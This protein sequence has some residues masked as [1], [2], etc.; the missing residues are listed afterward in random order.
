MSR[1]DDD[2]IRRVREATDLVALASERVVLRQKGRVFWG[3]CPFHDEK[4]PSFKIDPD[5]QLWHCFGCGKGGDV[6]GYVMESENVDFP[7]AVRELA[8]RAHIE[9]KETGG[10]G[11]PRSKR[12]RMMDACKDAEEFYHRQLMRSR[13]KGPASARAYLHG[14]GFGSKAS[15]DWMLGYAPGRGALVSYLKGKGYTRDVLIDA[16]LAVDRDGRLSDRFYERVI[17]PVHDVQGRCVAFGGRVIGEGEPKYLNSSETPIFHKSD[18]L[19]GVD[20]AK[21]AMVNTRQAVV[22]EGYTDVI[23]LHEAGVT[24]AVAALGTS[25]TAQ[26][27][28]LLSRFA[29]T[30]V[31]LFD[32]DAAGQKA[33][34]R[35][36]EFIDWQSAIES[37]RDPIDLRVVVIPDDKDP[38]DYIESDGPEAM[39]KLIAEKSEP[40]LQF[41]INRCLDGYDLRKPEQKSHAMQQALKILYP[42]KGSVSA[43]DYVN[44]IADRLNVD[45]SSVLQAFRETKAPAA[46]RRVEEDEA[47]SRARLTQPAS[48]AAADI[49]E[50]DQQSVR[51]ERKLVSLV[52][53]DTHL[54]DDMA[55]EIARVNWTDEASERMADAL[56]ELDRDATPAQAL[57][58][59]TAVCPEAPSLLS[60]VMGESSEDEDPSYEA[61]LLVRSL[62]ERDLEGMIRQSKARMRTQAGLSP[63]ELDELFEETVAM[64]KELKE[65]RTQPS[66]RRQQQSKE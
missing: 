31:Y 13:E 66:A 46:A 58:A 28:K 11:V 61:R 7:D 59:V 17:F 24:N 19:Y 14:R 18:N 37:R 55:A 15:N 32:G 3:C 52:V 38:A 44:L 20:R 25:L 60:A 62:R 30:I 26:H 54:L 21:S 47:V 36:S 39:R 35:A 65:L 57:M 6:F 64:Q 53:T 48:R 2:D 5:T 1:I 50:T 10:S 27:V 22:V 63:Q 8:D 29:T 34:N 45:Y 16:N 49:M 43:T 56:F 9:I 40:L 41:A 33:A 4:T 51:M 23:A 12:E 42:L